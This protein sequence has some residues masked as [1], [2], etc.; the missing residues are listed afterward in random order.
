MGLIALGTARVC[1]IDGALT[2]RE[3]ALAPACA[4]VALLVVAAP[5][6]A[7]PRQWSSGLAAIVA[8]GLMQLLLAHT[9]RG[10]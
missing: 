9:M 7:R 10:P 4:V 6:A 2:I 8:F 5:A 1:G 3:E